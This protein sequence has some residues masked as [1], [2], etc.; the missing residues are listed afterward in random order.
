MKRKRNIPQLLNRF[1]GQPQYCTAQ[2]GDIVASFLLK[3]SGIDTTLFFDPEE[4]IDEYEDVKVALLDYQDQVEIVEETGENSYIRAD[5][6]GVQLLE[7]AVHYRPVQSM[8]NPDSQTYRSVHAELRDL[9]HDTRVK[10]V[11]QRHASPG[12]EGMGLDQCATN[13][14]ALKADTGKPLWAYCEQS[15]SASYYLSAVADRII[16]NDQARVANIGVYVKHMATFRALQAQ[17]IDTTYI[18]SGQRKLDGAQEMPLSKEYTDELKSMVD[19]ARIDFAQHVSNY[20]NLELSAVMSTEGAAMSG[21]AAQSAGL[22]DDV[23]E[24]NEALAEFSDHLRTRSV[25]SYEDTNNIPIQ[26]KPVMKGAEIQNARSE[27]LQEGIKLAL[28]VMEHPAAKAQPQLAQSLLQSGKSKQEVVNLLDAVDLPKYMED[29][30]SK[31]GE[32]GDGTGGK[33]RRLIRSLQDKGYTNEEIGNR[34]N[35]S[36]GTIGA[37]ASGEIANPPAELVDDLEDMDRN[38]ES[39]TQAQ[40]LALLQTMQSMM[41]GDVN[42]IP[43]NPEDRR[44]TEAK[45]ANTKANAQAKEAEAFKTRMANMARATGY[46]NPAATRGDAE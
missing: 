6:I 45:A 7:G 20:R 13:I 46:R 11:L 18:A 30:E 21:F 26:E 9:F 4:E 29:D 42:S 43:N 25:V 2:Y 33:A 39:K 22:I 37:I 28:S 41:S 17:G 34:T 27:G 35:R 15:C 40:T 12:G 24:D 3:E 14:A 44:E 5:G 1:F 16:A 32:A 10:G 23:M 8:S 31:K 38:T 19:G 36:A